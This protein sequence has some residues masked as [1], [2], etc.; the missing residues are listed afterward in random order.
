[1]FIIVKCLGASVSIVSWIH[2]EM[3]QKIWAL[4]EFINSAWLVTP[5]Q[6][7]K[8]LHESLFSRLKTDN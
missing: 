2:R 4:T 5:P 1:M 8:F 3:P 6:N 7:I